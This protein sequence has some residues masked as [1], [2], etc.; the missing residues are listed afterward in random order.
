[1]VIVSIS[2]LYLSLFR[3]FY[4]RYS[5]IKFIF[6]R[7]IISLASV[8][9]STILS[10]ALKIILISESSLECSIFSGKVF[11]LRVVKI[12]CLPYFSCSCSNKQLLHNKRNKKTKI[13]TIYKSKFILTRHGNF[14]SP[15]FKVIEKQN[16]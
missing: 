14:R 1:M 8:P 15:C 3:Y 2:F 5:S 6:S 16:F 4:T 12:L 13:K 7:N 11:S 10:N 9:F